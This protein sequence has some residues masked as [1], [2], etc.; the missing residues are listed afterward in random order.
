MRKQIL[1]RKSAPLVEMPT[2]LKKNASK[3]LDRIMKNIVRLVIGTKEKQNSHITNVLEMDLKIIYLQNVQIHQKRTR[4]IGIKYVLMKEVI[5]HH[6]KNAK[7]VKIKI[8]KRY[9]HPC[10]TC[11]MMTNVL[12]GILVT[13]RNRPIGFYIHRK[14]FI[15]CQRFPTLF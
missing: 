11:L 15:W 7:T 3:G 6:R 8:T 12:V 5:L 4:N 9:M 1:S 2:I 10:H 14:H 13:V